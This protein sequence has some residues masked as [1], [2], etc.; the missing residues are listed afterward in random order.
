M[1]HDHGVQVPASWLLIR[2]GWEVVAADGDR[3][4]EV[5]EVVGDET[6]DIFDGLALALSALAK[7]RYVPAEQVATITEGVVHVSLS[8][9]EVQSL[10]EY[11]EPASSER[12]VADSKSGLSASV[13]ELEGKVFAP[14]QRRQGSVSLLRRI[15]LWIRRQ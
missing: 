10:S 11:L 13:R 3:V 6:R 14:T 1:C 9:A 4:G 12:I 2:P 8:A 5:V 15:Y 7:P